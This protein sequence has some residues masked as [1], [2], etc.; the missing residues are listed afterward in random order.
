MGRTR[1]V[2]CQSSFTVVSQ[3]VNAEDVSLRY[4]LITY[5]RECEP[6]DID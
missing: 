4:G 1:E 2:F 6:V 3:R 5:V